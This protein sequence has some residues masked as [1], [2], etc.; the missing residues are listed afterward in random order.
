MFILVCFRPSG[1]KPLV[2]IFF[3]LVFSVFL[4][5]WRKENAVKRREKA[6]IYFVL[7]KLEIQFDFY[8]FLFWNQIQKLFEQLFF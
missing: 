8:L 7:V 6:G 3:V 2:C 4:F 1:T 5:N